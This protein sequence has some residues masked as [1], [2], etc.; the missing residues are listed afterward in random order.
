MSYCRWS[1]RCEDGKLSDIYAYLHCAGGVTVHFAGYRQRWW[2][3]ILGRVEAWARDLGGDSW[4]DDLSK[5]PLE[6]PNGDMVPRMSQDGA[7]YREPIRRVALW[8]RMPHFGTELIGDGP[9]RVIRWYFRWPHW[10]THYAIPLPREEDRDG[11]SF[12]EA[13][14]FLETLRCKGWNVP[15]YA[16]R[17]LDQEDREDPDGWM[18]QESE[19]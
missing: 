4:H 5:P 17:A 7:W 19:T 18:K 10:M 3:D 6:F 15:E 1:S 11:L 14:R 13:A 8:L 12:A 2:Y 16:I 9:T